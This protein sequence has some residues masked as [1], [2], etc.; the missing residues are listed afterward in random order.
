M[1]RLL[2]ISVL[3]YLFSSLS[4]FSAETVFSIETQKQVSLKGRQSGTEAGG[5]ARG[6]VAPT[7]QAFVDDNILMLNFGETVLKAVVVVTD[8][9]SGEVAYSGVFADPN[10]VLINIENEGEYQLELQIGCCFLEGVFS[11]R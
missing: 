2:F 1:K 3:L 8:L 10:A 9:N 5:I 7:I 6:R 11:I 4:A